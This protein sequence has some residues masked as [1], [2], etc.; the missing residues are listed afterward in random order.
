[1]TYGHRDQALTGRYENSAYNTVLNGVWKFWYSDSHRNL[2]ADGV[3]LVADT[4][5]WHNIEVPGN[6]EVQGYGVPIYTN[7][8]YAFKAHNPQ[9]PQSPDDIPTGIY[10]RDINTPLECS[11]RYI[12]LHLAGATPGTYVPLHGQEAG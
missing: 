11:E 8:G 12:H 5:A 1:M 3:A 4:T 9:P 10:R 2:P 6:W 7:H